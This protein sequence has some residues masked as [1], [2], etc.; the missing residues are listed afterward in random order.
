MLIE[1]TDR[2][3]QRIETSVEAELALGEDRA[4]VAF[5]LVTVAVCVLAELDRT[6]AGSRVV[7]DRLRRLADDL[8]AM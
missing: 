8:D 1:A 3:L 2:S 5:R 7:A 4:M 6:G